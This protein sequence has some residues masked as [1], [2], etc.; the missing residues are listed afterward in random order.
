MT[1]KRILLALIFVI[2]IGFHV[3]A[4]GKDKAQAAYN[5]GD[6]ETALA[7]WEKT[8]ARFEKRHKAAQCT[9]YAK[10]GKTAL[11]LGKTDEARQLFEKAIYSASVSPSAFVELAK[12]YRKIDNLSLEITT[13]EKYVK[14]YPEGKEIIPMRQRLFDTYI[15]SE[16]WQE[17]LNLW[18][19][20]PETFRN[21]PSNK[22]KL[23]KADIA[24]NRTSAA[25]K[26]A[27]E[28]LAAHPD[29]LTALD[30][31]AKKYF[32]RAENRYQSE[33]KAYARNKTR[34]QYAH[35]LKAFRVVTADFKKSLSYFRKLYKLQ[36]SSENA[37]FLGN[38]Y[39]RLDNA[40]KAKYYQHL[41][42]QLKQAGK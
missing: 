8:I 6:Y 19:K 7:L 9:V 39:A 21:E 29:N 36:P 30:Y 27:A 22:A 41:A 33:M 40:S 16:N 37:R 18:G 11:K 35:L 34:A 20:L 3:S 38:I 42:D 13:L 10:A 26:L 14:K 17:A 12:I 1:M 2:P 32:W 24:L 25:D 5:R 23:L 4:K 15:E 31:E 28:V